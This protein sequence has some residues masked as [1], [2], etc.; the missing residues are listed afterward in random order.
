[1][2]P[3]TETMPA[4]RKKKRP[5]HIPT[6]ELLCTFHDKIQEERVS[7]GDLTRWTDGRALGILL[8]L[9]ALP[10][11]IPMIGLSAILAT[12]IF[13]IGCYMLVYGGQ[14][15]LPAWLLRRSIRGDLVRTAIDRATPVVRRLDRI[16]RPRLP[17]LA[18]AGRLHGIIAILMAVL[19]AVPIPGINILAAF[20]VAG[21]GI[22]I[23]QRDGLLVALALA[24]ALAA[25]LGAAGVLTGA[26]MLWD[27]LFD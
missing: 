4:R 7:L 23:V 12:P 3:D 10:E 27:N 13:V 6:A 22:A 8:L 11:T 20:S 21:I 25:L 1:M 24:L 2:E 14:P 15:R 26:F 19:L 16:A 17:L 18:G 9:L 5:R